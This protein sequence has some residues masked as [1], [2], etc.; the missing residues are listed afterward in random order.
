MGRKRTKAILPT[1]GAA[2]AI[3]LEDGRFGVCRVLRG[4]NPDEAKRMGAEGVLV[5]CSAWI[6]PEVP[7]AHDPAL[8]TIL[9]LTH[10]KWKNV[11]EIL[12]ISEPPPTDFIPIGVIDPAPEETALE[13]WTSG[14]WGSVQIQP[15][16]QWR[17]DHDRDAVLAADKILAEEAAEKAQR[18]QQARAK[19]LA[20]ATLATLLDR[21]FFPKWTKHP[22]KKAVLASRRIMR[23]TVQQLLEI[24]VTA[25][26]SERMAVLQAC[27]ERFNSLDEELGHFIET[28]ERDEICEEFEA[29]V[30]ACG[31]DAHEDLADEWREW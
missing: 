1:A 3:P 14:G 29:I 24:G 12:W 21:K 15:L 19:S 13:C 2:F 17:W 9:H 10:H 8:R 28:I 18:M 16:A 11:P 30:H 4:T 20:G 23:D 31:L 6:G 27:I 26:E 7:D 22:P 5:A 25:P